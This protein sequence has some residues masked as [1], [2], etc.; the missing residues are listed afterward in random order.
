MNP[1]YEFL[2][3]LLTIGPIIAPNHFYQMPHASCRRTRRYDR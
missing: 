1:R 2:F 3:E